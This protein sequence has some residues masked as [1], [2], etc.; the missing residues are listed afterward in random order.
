MAGESS[1]LNHY[2]RRCSDKG[3]VENPLSDEEFFFKFK[4][5]TSLALRPEGVEEVLYLLWHLEES[6]DIL[7]LMELLTFGR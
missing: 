5:C 4:D 6:K 7:R 3:T 2:K 1:N